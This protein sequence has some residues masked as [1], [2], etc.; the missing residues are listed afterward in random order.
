MDSL[1]LSRSRLLGICSAVAMTIPAMLASNLARAEQPQPPCH[2]N[3]NA[4]ADSAAVADRGDVVN[5]PQPLKD[6]LVQLADRPHSYLPLQVFAE[7]DNPSQLFQYYLLE[8]TGFE[9]NVFTT[10]FRGVNDHVQLTV[11]GGNCGLPT[12]GAVRVVLEPKPGLPTDPNNPRAFNDVFTDIS[13]L[14][15]INNES[16]WYEGWMIH[17]I[18][19]P[20]T[21]KPRLDGHAQFGAITARDAALLKAMG[22]GNNVPGHIFTIDGQSPHVPSAS[23]HFPDRQ[24]NVVPIHVS[25]GAYNSLQQGDAHAYW[26]FNYQGTNWVHPLY[27][28]PF[29]GGFP[30]NFGQPADTFQDGE[31]GALQSIVPGPGPSGEQNKPQAVGDDPN[32]PRDPDK[33]D[34]DNGFD[35]QREFRE[36]GVPSGLGNEIY[37]DVYER[38]ASFEPE[39]TNLQKRLFDAYAAEVRRV[40]GND[41]GIVTAARGDIDTPTDGFPDNT[42]LYLPPTTFN[43]F[44]V[45]REIN[46]GLLAPRFAPSQRAWVLSG[47]RVAVDPTVS[48]SAGRD[49]DDR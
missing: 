9:P 35:A 8:T 40:T 7:A 21:A 23:D 44:A 24:T 47:V 20:Q 32:L 45:T 36:R 16:G 22:A 30:D 18:T 39:I 17:D 10:I 43:R 11:T 48:A 26:E 2:P 46:D 49:A 33:F 14:F 1:S 6:R 12:V 28:L 34:A 5:L 19:V 4:V 29:T 31:I 25:M 41:D 13:P 42:R 3:P 27:E 38:R 37:L 15:V